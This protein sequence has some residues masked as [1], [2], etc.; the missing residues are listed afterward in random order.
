MS[1]IGGK[2]YNKTGLGFK[3]GK[4]GTVLLWYNDWVRVGPL[5]HLYS[6]LFTVVFNE[7][8]QSFVKKC[9]VYIRDKC[10]GK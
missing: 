2:V 7:S 5:C 3:V 6:R 9:C 1:V 4:K 8:I 10:H